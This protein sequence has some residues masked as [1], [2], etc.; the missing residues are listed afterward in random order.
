VE[1]VPA[2]SFTAAGEV[3]SGAGAPA[4]GMLLSNTRTT[5]PEGGAR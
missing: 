1:A 2:V 4:L 5:A 3:V